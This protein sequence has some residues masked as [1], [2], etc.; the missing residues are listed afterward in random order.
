MPVH[1]ALHMQVYNWLSPSWQ[2]P[3]VPHG[4]PAHS[5]KSDDKRHTNVLANDN[6]YWLVSI[7]RHLKKA[8]ILR[9][10]RERSRLIRNRW[11]RRKRSLLVSLLRGKKK[12]KIYRNDGGKTP[13]SANINMIDG[14]LKCWHDCRVSICFYCSMK[15]EKNRWTL[16]QQKHKTL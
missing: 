12:E 10:R 14:A 1:P 16:F 15:W 5:F 13:H 11:L 6:C 9:N 2:W 4:L 8:D 3:F 7:A